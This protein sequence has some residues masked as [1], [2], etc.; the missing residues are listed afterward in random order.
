MKLEVLISTMNL[1]NIDENIELMKKMN[2][3]T[4]SLTINQITKPE[5]RKFDKF[6]VK[7]KIISKKEKGLS[8]SR[9]LAIKS[10]ETDICILADDDVIYKNGYEK[11]IEKEYEKDKKSDIICFWVESDNNRRKIKRMYTSRIGKIRA[12]RVRSVQITFR[13]DSILKNNI[14]FDENFGAGTYYDRGEEIIFLR[15]CIEKGLKV[16]FVNKKIADVS[17]KKSTWFKGY[18]EIFFKKQ[19]VI[20]YRMSPKYYKLLIFQ[21]AIRKYKLYKNK[22][23]MKDA[24]KYMLMGV[25]KY[26]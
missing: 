4:N 26:R 9:N 18:N 20:F 2:V 11:I 22:L 12:M 10:A 13:R 23:K 17:Q 15:E 19:G 25:E 5:I 14:K 7:N 6:N 21:F 16:K 3:K 8:R 24:V 1:K